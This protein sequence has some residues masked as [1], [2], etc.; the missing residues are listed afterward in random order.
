MM[1]CGAS[2][3]YGFGGDT[4]GLVGQ[5]NEGAAKRALCKIARTAPARMGR[6][7]LSDVLRRYSSNEGFER[8]GLASILKPFV[9][10]STHNTGEPP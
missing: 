9:I 5:V 6:H 8:I 1:P 4:V 7:L 10:G 2:E 3:P